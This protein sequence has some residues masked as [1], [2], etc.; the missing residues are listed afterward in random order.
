MNQLDYGYLDDNM[1]LSNLYILFKSFFSLDSNLGSLP[2]ITVFGIICSVN[3]DISWLM[4]VWRT[5]L[6]LR[7]KCNICNYQVVCTI[8]L[9]ALYTK[10]D[11][12][13]IWNFMLD[14]SLSGF[15]LLIR[16]DKS[17]RIELFHNIFGD[18]RP[19][20]I[21]AQLCK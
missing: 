10:L 14:D 21:F 16:P 15:R 18:L 9:K 11:Q 8:H 13:T 17:Y 1:V 20:A 12:W 5:S 3:T 6:G 19:K 2:D 7:T 4:T